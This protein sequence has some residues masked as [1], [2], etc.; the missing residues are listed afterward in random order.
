MTSRSQF[1]APPDINAGSRDAGFAS[2]IQQYKT[3]NQQQQ[4]AL[5][6]Q[7]AMRWVT[8]S[9]G[10]G[11]I[12]GLLVM[13]M[14]WLINPPMVRESGKSNLEK[15]KPSLTKVVGWGV[16]SGSIVALTPILMKVSQMRSSDTVQL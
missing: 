3:N 14:L 4:G 7:K 5:L 6:K 16:I 13:V 10:L 9:V 2:A 1:Q 8:S 12:V 15:Q 11:L